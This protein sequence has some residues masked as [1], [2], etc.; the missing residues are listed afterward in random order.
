MTVQPHQNICYLQD[1]VL[2]ALVLCSYGVQ[3]LPC[4]PRRSDMQLADTACIRR[5]PQPRPVRDL[6][7]IV[8]AQDRGHNA[9]VV[10]QQVHRLRDDRVHPSC[11][12]GRLRDMQAFD[13]APASHTYDC[14]CA[15]VE[16]HH[17]KFADGLCSRYV[18]DLESTLH[19]THMG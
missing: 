8:G 18:A 10:P 12:G 7:R 5:S 6:P 16:A 14:S 17:I 1:V 15:V 9:C 13:T 4:G 3:H 11:S 19:T 2:A